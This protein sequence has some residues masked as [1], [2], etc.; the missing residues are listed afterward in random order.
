MKNSR[1]IRIVS[2]IFLITLLIP[3]TYL[4]IVFSQGE[5]GLNWTQSSYDLSRT[6]FNPQ[7]VIT[8]DNVNQLQLQWIHRLPRNLY[9]GK[10]VPSENGEGDEGGHEDEFTFVGLENSEGIEANPLVINGF[11]YV[12]TSFGVLEAISASTGNTV[13]SFKVNVTAALE[14][15]W[16]VNRGIQR[17]I[18]YYDEKIFVQSIDCSIYGLEPTT[19]RVLIEIQDT[20]KDIPG[21]RGQYYGEESP[22]FYRD[23]AIVTGASGF[24]Q[25]RGYVAAYDLNSGDLLWRWFA[26]PPMEY[27]ETLNVEWEKGNIAPYLNDW[28]GSND[29]TVG[30]GAAIRTIGVVDDEKGVVYLGVGPPVARTLAVHGHP[31]MNEIPGPNLYSN[32]VVA[33]DAETGQLIWYY[34]IDPH[35]VHRQGIYGSLILTTIEV[36]GDLKDVV[37]APSF[38][39]F[40]YV[41][42][43]D[44]GTPVYEPIEVGAVF[45]SHNGNKGNDADM[46]ANQD[47]IEVTAK[48]EFVFCPGSEGGISAPMAIHDNKIF[49]ATQNDCFEVRKVVREGETFWAYS[50]YRPFQQNSSLYSIDASNGDIIWKYDMRHL[51]WFSG[52]TVSGGVVYTLDQTGILYMVDEDRGELLRKIQFDF[53]GD[54]GV[55]IGAA[56]NG[57]MMLFVVVGTSELVMPTE[58]MVLAFALPDELIASEGTIPLISAIIMAIAIIAVYT[59]VL[60]LIY[61]R[62]K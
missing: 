27:G 24:G 35:D 26:S 21:N 55:S 22:I 30:A 18:T 54:A 40:V 31:S 14:K 44:T 52:V 20:C 25:S 23:I 3:I 5:V 33:L 41:L 56:A 59:I 2:T 1:L 57:K 36:G 48:G 61:L 19:G 51:H 39:G 10:L 16:I 62:K 9:E 7:E 38:Q 45:N 28:V 37:I 50:T 46:E 29:N 53:S 58:G 60:V 12:Q 34:Q 42:D 32:T 43:S 15:P 47:S 11:V 13:W 17:S 49:V 4:G 8:K 6:G